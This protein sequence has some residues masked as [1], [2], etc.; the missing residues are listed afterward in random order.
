MKEV[1]LF[2]MDNL[3]FRPVSESDLDNIAMLDT[4]F[5]IR[6]F[7]PE[8]IK[9]QFLPAKHFAPVRSAVLAGIR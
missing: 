5:E 8:W 2:K 3:G 9:Q 6:S 1:Y 4:D 7:F